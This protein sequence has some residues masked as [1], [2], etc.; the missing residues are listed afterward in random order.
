MNEPLLISRQELIRSFGF[1][2]TLVQELGRPDYVRA[3]RGWGF[4]YFYDLARVERFAEEHAE[5]LEHILLAR[6]ARQE[7]ARATSRRRSEEMVTWSRT[8]PLLLEPIPPHALEHARRYFAPEAL[9]RERALLYLR[10]HY[11][12]YLECLRYVARAY[13]AAEARLVLCERVEVMLNSV[14]KAQESEKIFP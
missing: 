1:S 11:T 10:L 13:G 9:T 6:P 8:V 12:N 3:N 14:L 2:A 7:R 4:T 5:R